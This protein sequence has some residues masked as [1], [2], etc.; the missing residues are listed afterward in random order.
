MA[1]NESDFASLIATLE[2]MQ[3]LTL[4]PNNPITVPPKHKCSG[5]TSQA[6]S[7]LQIE[8]LSQEFTL[9]YFVTAGSVLTQT[10]SILAGI[11]P[12]NPAKW[13]KNFDGAE[14][15]AANVSDMNASM[16]VTLVSS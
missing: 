4:S 13:V 9:M 12:G 11:N 14:L 2:Q 6:I 10:G 8:N 5:P 3:N 1:D 15:I 7:Y 16:L